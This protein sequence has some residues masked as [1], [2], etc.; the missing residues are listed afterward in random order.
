MGDSSA[1]RAAVADLHVSDGGQRVGHAGE[2]G[3]RRIDQLRVGRRGP[4]GK[5]AVGR[6]AHPAEL[7][8]P[9]D[10]DQPIDRREPKL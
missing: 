10:V 5:A 8:D 2:G 6:L 9:A 1:D 4:D 7:L 3:D